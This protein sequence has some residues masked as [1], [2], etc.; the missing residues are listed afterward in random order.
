MKVRVE[1]DRH[2]S[3]SPGRC[4]APAPS[5]RRLQ[6]RKVGARVPRRVYWLR[7]NR[8]G[9]REAFAFPTE[10]EARV[11]M[12]RLRAA[13][14]LGQHYQPKAVVHA[15]PTFKD[16]AE[17]ALA[18]YAR[19]NNP[20]PATLKNHASYLRAHLVP[21]FG[22][23]PVSPETFN[24]LALREFIA[25][26]REVMQDSTLR[27]SLPTLSL[28][29]DYAV[30]K[31][32]LASNPLRGGGRLWRPQASEAVTPFTPEQVREVQATARAVDHD[33]G[34]LVQTM[35]QTGIRPGEALGVRRCDLDLERAEL[36]IEGSWSH[37]RLGPT[38]TDPGGV[39]AL[40]GVGDPPDPAA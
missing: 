18:L 13:E 37:N 9:R 33:F 14:T 26:Q 8:G 35:F 28:C 4:V 31:G 40:S 27:S 15:A 39:A 17:A 7:V 1:Q 12:E 38:P 22:P 20:S 23:R 29:L 10:G 25:A 24:R 30:E 32:L 3:C 21:A 11:A 34:V 36:H 16:I 19:T 5:T 2:G 6:G